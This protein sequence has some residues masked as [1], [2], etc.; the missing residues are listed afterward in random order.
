LTVPAGLTNLGSLLL[1][2]NLLTNLV[3]PSDL[4]R[5]QTIDVG[6][7]ALTSLNLPPGLTH[8]TGLFMIVNQLTT[9]TLP[10]D[11]I[12]L[13]SLSFLQNPF[14]TLVI[15][16]TLA[17]STNLQVN[18]TTLS[19]LRNQGVTVFTYPPALR[20]A[21]P[22]RTATGAFKFTLTGP[23]GRYTILTS[24]NLS[25]WSASGAMTN[26]VGSA[27]FTDSAVSRQKF[28]RATTP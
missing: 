19:E 26:V 20:L 8:L 14:T 6:G 28:F 7:N 18:L 10:P 27:D 9:L 17:A 3:L 2:G 23:P 13:T 11:M 1:S 25:N 12:N 24:T 22:Q 21:S 16:E 5:L 15:S 4:S